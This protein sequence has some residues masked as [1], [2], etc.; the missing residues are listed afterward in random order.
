MVVVVV[1][2]VRVGEGASV[3]HGGLKVRAFGVL[4]FSFVGVLVATQGL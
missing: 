4:A 1:I 3:H 2:K